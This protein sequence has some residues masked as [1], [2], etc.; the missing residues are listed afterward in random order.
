[1]NCTV[2]WLP[3]RIITGNNCCWWIKSEFTYSAMYNSQN[4]HTNESK[5][6]FRLY[7]FTCSGRSSY[8]QKFIRKLISSAESSGLNTI[9]MKLLWF[10]L[11]VFRFYWKWSGYNWLY[12]IFKGF[13]IS[14]NYHATWYIHCR[15]WRG[16]LAHISSTRKVKHSSQ[17]TIS[18]YF[19]VCDGLN[20][21]LAKFT[22][23]LSW[24]FLVQFKWKRE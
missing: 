14:I 15:K 13:Q 24:H 9:K 22:T 19:I 10:D 4:I 16:W 21:H 12:D 17:R 23:T 2:Q 6:T 8:F 5:P 1:M 20:C 18:F 3:M 11:K 7:L